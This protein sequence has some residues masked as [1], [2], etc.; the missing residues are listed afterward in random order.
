M[1]RN[2]KL[3]LFVGCVFIVIL[4]LFPYWIHTSPRAE[5]YREDAGRHFIL[6][7]PE[8][9]TF[10]SFIQDE[11]TT[12]PVIDMEKLFLEW[13]LVIA[14]AGTIIL[15]ITETDALTKTRAPFDRRFPG[16][17][18]IILFISGLYI[19][20]FPMLRL[21]A[22]P[23]FLIFIALPMILALLILLFFDILLNIVRQGFR[24]MKALLFIEGLLIL[25]FSVWWVM[26]FLRYMRM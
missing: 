4:G 26:G 19:Y 10:S 3:V 13:L 5:F 14:T 2:Q 24:W 15:F 6:D 16:A 7:K 17:F 25:S 23:V 21:G 1:N 8:A 20:W 9:I 22:A 18:L 12:E 11:V